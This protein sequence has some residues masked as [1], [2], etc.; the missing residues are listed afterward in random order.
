MKFNPCT[1]KCT[2]EGSHYEG[3][4]CSHEEIAEMR[5]PVAMLVELAHKMQYENI[6]DFAQAV[7]DS[8]KYEMELGY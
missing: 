7:A 8:S 4:G 1:G 5:E 6:D 2:E 3:C